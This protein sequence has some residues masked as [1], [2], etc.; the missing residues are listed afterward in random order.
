MPKNPQLVSKA[1]SMPNLSAGAA[2]SARVACPAAAGVSAPV[3]TAPHIHHRFKS[4]EEE[5]EEAH[6]K[7]GMEV[8]DAEGLSGRPEET[9]SPEELATVVNVLQGVAAFRTLARE[10]V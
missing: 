7:T 9:L 2:V 10:K 6:D 1:S 5:E 8:V 3:I 4:E